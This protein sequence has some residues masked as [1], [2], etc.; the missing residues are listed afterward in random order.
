MT[1]FAGVWDAQPKNLAKIHRKIFPPLKHGPVE[2]G[3]ALQPR[4]PN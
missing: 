4:K 2:L 3:F 1:T